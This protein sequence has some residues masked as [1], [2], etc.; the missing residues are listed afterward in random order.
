[1]NTRM[2]I[3]A[4]AAA[5][6]LAVVSPAAMTSTFIAS[7]EAHEMSQSDLRVTLNKL[8]GEHVSLAAAAT[9]AALHG[10]QAQFEAA[11][12]ALD[13]NSLDLAKAIGS[14]YGQGAQDAFLPLWRK[15]IEFFV[16]YTVA[17]AENNAEA[18]KSA[19][20]DL[21]GYAEDFGAFLN[22]ANENL[23]KDAVAGLVREHVTTLAAVVDAQAK[24]D[25]A[26]AYEAER[27]AYGHMQHI[28]DAL[29]EAIA[30]QFPKKFGA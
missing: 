9:G 26:A 23:P 8:L 24:K 20:D 25:Y 13:N 15:H 22:S 5:L 11:A 28:S 7:A 18:K 27:M 1:M 12:G 19:V 29:A 30:E 17:T 4:G 16:N 6:A 14:V 10:Q 2:L 3:R 21:M